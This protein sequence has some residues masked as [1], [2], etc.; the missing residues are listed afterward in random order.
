MTTSPAQLRVVCEKY[1][2]ISSY[3]LHRVIEKEMSG[4]LEFAMLSILECSINPAGYFAERLY[5]SMAGAGTADTD[6]IRVI[7]SRC[8]LYR[9]QLS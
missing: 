2:E 1:R 5:K 4:N 6:L 9:G 7:V 3:D 8:V